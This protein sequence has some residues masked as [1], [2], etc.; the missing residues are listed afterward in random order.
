MWH[1]SILPDVNLVH[2]T[3]THIPQLEAWWW[4]LN[5]TKVWRWDGSKFGSVRGRAP[6]IL[7]DPVTGPSI[8]QI[9]ILRR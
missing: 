9:P 1:S 7:L 4:T 5:V 3:R 6:R 2:A 8:S